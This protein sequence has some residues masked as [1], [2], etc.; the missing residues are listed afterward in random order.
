MKKR[1]AAFLALLGFM[2]YTGAYIF[3][4]LWRAFRAEVPENIDFVSIHHSDNFAR[5]ILVAVL[6]LIGLVVVLH[7]TLV[8][9]QG[10]SGR[11]RLRP[12]LEQWVI[13]RSDE[14]R[15]DPSRLADRAV[16]AY[17]ARLEGRRSV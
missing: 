10:G 4:Y 5:S 9:R 3:I 1:Q 6:F 8:R 15:E 2:A 17:R 11:V 7:I 13:E 12:D 16:D 14:M